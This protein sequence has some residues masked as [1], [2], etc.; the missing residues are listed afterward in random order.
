MKS[1]GLSFLLPAA[2]FVAGC[3]PSD[4]ELAARYEGVVRSY[5]LECHDDA[6]RE[7]GLTLEGVDL[8][9]VSAH[10]ELFENVALKLR[11]RAMPPTGGPRPDAET[12][13]G[14]VAYL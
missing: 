13:D 1:R 2:A 6:G 8:D 12:Y 11:A 4:E 9:T 14:F 10:P 7:A 3:Q 5:C